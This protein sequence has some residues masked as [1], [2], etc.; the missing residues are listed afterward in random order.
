MVPDSIDGVNEEAWK[1][2]LTGVKPINASIEALL[3]AARPV[4]YE[5]G[6]LTLGVYYKFHK[7]RLEDLN[8]RKILEDVATSVL[9][10]PTRINCRLVEPPPKEIIEVVVK[11]ETVL[12]EGEDRDIIKVA[13]ELFSN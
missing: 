1:M 2:I 4:S 5:G 12:T 3:R 7:E 13:E 9:N 11:K 8:H 6:I 10:S